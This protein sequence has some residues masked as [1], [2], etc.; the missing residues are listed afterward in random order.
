MIAGGNFRERIF[1]CCDLQTRR[2]QSSST[3][4][5]GVSHSKVES[6]SLEYC[7]DI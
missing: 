2:A 5:S 6:I 1:G 3:G 7:V 4:F